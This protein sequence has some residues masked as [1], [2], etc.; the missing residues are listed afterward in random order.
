MNFSFNLP[1]NLLFGFG[2]IGEIGKKSAMYG[3][4]AMIVTGRGS[5]KKSGLLAKAELH[6]EQSG[7]DSVVFDN[8]DPNPLTTS[9]YE[10]KALAEAEK[11][12]MVIG[13]GGGSIMDAAK[14]IAFAAKNEGDLTDYI[15]ARKP[16]GDALPIILAPTTCGTGS[17]GNGFAVLTDPLTGDKKSLRSNSIIAKL[18]IVDPELMKTMPK[19]VLSSVGFDALCH[20]M[21]AYLSSLGQPLSD[22]IALEGIKLIHESLADLCGG[23]GGDEEWEKLTLASTFGG[24]SIGLAGVTA[25]HGIEHPASGLRNVVHGA[26]LAALTPTV[27]E[28]SISHAPV[29]FAEISRRLGGRDERD[30][31]EG[32]RSLLDAID[33]S[34]GLKEQ[35]IRESDIDWMAENCFKVSA[36]SLANHPV[37]FSIDEIKDLYRMSL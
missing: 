21:E 33:L 26:G 34:I 4:K 6:L 25:A 20:C 7:V 37:K 29:K 24:M 12:D 35:G 31:V 3:K 19:R 11:C 14:A 22:L 17:E 15:F 27:F 18:S 9:I 2:A 23:F 10:G 36:A 8:V 28:R 32:I 13:L 30:C 5:A 16:L 1:V